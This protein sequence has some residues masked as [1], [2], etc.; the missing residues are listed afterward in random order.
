MLLA[1]STLNR[2]NLNPALKKPGRGILGVCVAGCS[3]FTATSV[4]V[5]SEPPP[6]GGYRFSLLC[7]TAAAMTTAAVLSAVG[8]LFSFLVFRE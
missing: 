1:A 5:K 8:L 7:V 3:A 4:A 2:N 6:A